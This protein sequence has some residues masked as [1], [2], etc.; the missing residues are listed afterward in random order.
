MR[1]HRRLIAVITMVGC[2]VSLTACAWPLGTNVP[3]DIRIDSVTDVDFKSETQLEWTSVK[4]RPSITVS[5]IDFST[6]TDLL[7][8]AREGG[9]AS[10]DASKLVQWCL[11]SR[12]RAVR[13]TA[14][15]GVWNEAYASGQTR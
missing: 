11:S 8:L 10:P 1:T 2:L 6:N 7:A 15:G 4:P 12:F 5:R 9:D 14:S 3:Q 13:V